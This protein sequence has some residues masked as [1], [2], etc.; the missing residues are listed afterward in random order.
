MNTFI[1]GAGFTH[2]IDK[3]C[4]LNSGLLKE[5]IEKAPEP[6]S[7]SPSSCLTAQYGA[8]DIEVALTRLDIDIA[9]AQSHAAPTL[10]GLKKL[11]ADVEKEVADYFWQFA[12]SPSLRAKNV[13]LNGFLDGCIKKKD[14]VVSL[15]YD[16]VLEGLLCG[17]GKWRPSDGYGPN[18]RNP[19]A[20][21]EFPG[22][23]P[24]RV[25]KIHGSANFV[26]DAGQGDPEIYFNMT[27]HHFP[28]PSGIGD[29]RAVLAK[30][31]P[32][33]I[34]PSYVKS[35]AVELTCL[36]RDALK[37]VGKSDRLV[38]IGCGMRP[39]DHF[40]TLLIMNF[41]MPED[42]RDRRIIIVDLQAD[43]ITRRLQTFLKGNFAQ[44]IVSINDKVQNSIDRLKK[45]LQ[46]VAPKTPKKTKTK[47]SLRTTLHKTAGTWGTL[48][49]DGL[50][51]NKRQ[52]AEW[53]KRPDT[54]SLGRE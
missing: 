8:F 29:L 37:A 54:G 34:A 35:P 19:L 42:G 44:R 51:I 17:C 18:I 22:K 36:M 1:I 4:P 39:E 2:A 12:G 31:G 47:K 30:S 27:G 28:E 40:L 49:S 52:R 50:T 11:R 6:E 53:D 15:N 26:Y 20:R 32:A 3:E 24:V 45:A 48:K 9:V 16:C 25:L 46:P 21:H 10:E 23:S 41:L 43:Q 33:I 13:W 38:I 5:L 14:V 7:K